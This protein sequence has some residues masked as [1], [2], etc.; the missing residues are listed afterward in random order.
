M[1]DFGPFQTTLSEMLGLRLFKRMPTSSNSFSSS[2]LEGVG[3]DEHP[4]SRV[5]FPLSL[6]PTSYQPLDV[7]LD[8]V[9]HHENEIGGAGDSNDLLAAALALRRALDDTGQVQ[10]L[11]AGRVVL[12]R[13]VR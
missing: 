11:N 6:P 2:G 7:A 8:G 3:G 5:T 13:E 9:E 12:R 1:S 4:G 10:Q